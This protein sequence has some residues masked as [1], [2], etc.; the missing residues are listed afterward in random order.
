MIAS[1]LAVSPKI[2][3]IEARSAAVIAVDEDREESA[4]ERIH[5]GDLPGPVQRNDDSLPD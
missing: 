5:E 2:E 4:R 3:A 1:S